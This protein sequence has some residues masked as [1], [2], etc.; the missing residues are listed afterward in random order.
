MQSC[1]MPNYYIRE[2]RAVLG[3]ELSYR[4][5]A[6]ARPYRGAAPDMQ[7]HMEH[8]FDWTSSHT[9]LVQ[10]QY[11][12]LCCRCCCTQTSGRCTYGVTEHRNQGY[13]SE[14]MISKRMSAISTSLQAQ[15]VQ[16]AVLHHAN[17]LH[18]DKTVLCCI[19][20]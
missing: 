8:T 1:T 3:M 11:A 7:L 9:M 2:N 17:L 6:T 12:S 19:W 5:A 20:S 18:Q 15:Q 13:P 10:E 16:Y 14:R 4:S